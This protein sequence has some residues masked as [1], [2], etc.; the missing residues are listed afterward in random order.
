MPQDRIEQARQEALAL[1]R[2][3]ISAQSLGRHTKAEECYTRCHQMM[4]AI[5]NR[6]GEAAA[7]HHLATLLESRGDFAEA[8]RYYT[9]SFELFSVD[10]DE[11]NS[12]FSLFFQGL[13]QFKMQEESAGVDLL[14]QALETAFRLGPSYVQEAWSRL[15]QASGLLFARRYFALMLSLGERLDEFAQRAQKE[16]AN[17]DTTLH[18]VARL[19]QQVGILLVACARLWLPEEEGG[20]PAP[21]EELA[22]WILQS[23]VNIDQATG[24]SLAFTDLAAKAIQER[25]A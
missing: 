5:G 9:D 15:R 2:E 12:L 23:A 11:Q 14:L 24:S 16:Y 13:L 20:E 10:G 25:N 18:Q 22:M 21:A 6:N 4:K 17:P 7:L 3:G 19:S 8:Q 1:Y